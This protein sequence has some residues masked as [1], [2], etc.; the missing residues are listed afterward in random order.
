MNILKLLPYKYSSSI[1]SCIPVA[2]YH[3]SVITKY[4]TKMQ[5]QTNYKIHNNKTVNSSEKLTQTMCVNPYIVQPHWKYCL[6]KQAM[7]VASIIG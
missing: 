4:N 1:G 6:R 5:V 7:I 3:D 2:S